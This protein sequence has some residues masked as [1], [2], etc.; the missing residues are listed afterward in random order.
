M[1]RLGLTVVATVTV[2][3]FGS[4]TPAQA[5]PITSDTIQI[6]TADGLTVLTSGS[7]SEG[8]GSSCQVG[9]GGSL[10]FQC[11]NTS[12]SV[13]FAYAPG[14]SPADVGILLTEPDGSVSDLILVDFPTCCAIV[15]MQIFSDVD[16]IPF[17]SAAQFLSAL[18]N[19]PTASIPETGAFQDLT[20]I[21]FRL[22]A[23]RN[24]N[25]VSQVSPNFSFW[26][27]SDLGSEPV[28]EPASL[29][30]LGTG[31]LATVSRFRRR[32]SRSNIS[33]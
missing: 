12:I 9:F 2:A 28:P 33:Q 22:L 11:E 23:A 3:L 18:P 4:V 31:L 26:A 15:G 5:S 30:L 20:G 17:P 21:T 19:L 8:P 7:L 13:P 6:R 24:A 29:A 10:T 27:Q 25:L 32:R 1:N 14:T 16:G